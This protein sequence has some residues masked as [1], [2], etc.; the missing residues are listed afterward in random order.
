MSSGPPPPNEGLDGPGTWSTGRAVS[1][2]LDG[3]RRHFDVVI[4][5][6]ASQILQ[7]EAIPALYRAKQVIVAGGRHQLPPST[8]FATAVEAED[9]VAGA[10][11]EED[12]LATATA[13]IGGFESLLHTLGA[14]LPSWLLEWRYRSQDERLITFSTSHIYDGRLVTFPSARGHRAIRHVLVPH[15]PSVGGQDE[16]GSREGEEVVRQVLSHAETRPDE[17][18][19]VNHHG[20]RAREPRPGGARPR[21][22]APARAR[23]LLHR[24][25][26]GPPQVNG[27]GGR[28]S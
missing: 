28:T 4:V 14:F 8:F 2:R 18:L 9:D 11:E 15:D 5:D 12:A 27:S 19:G 16:S 22:R 20:H 10:D 1:Q 17:S 6:G 13:A 7:E 25:T 23:G 3:S 26:G 21:P 24:S